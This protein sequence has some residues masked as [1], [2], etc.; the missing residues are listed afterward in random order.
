MLR[1]FYFNITHGKWYKQLWQ[2]EN[3]VKCD[4][5]CNRPPIYESIWQLA[6][7]N[8]VLERWKSQLPLSLALPHLLFT[9]LIH[10]KSIYSC[11]CTS[12]VIRRTYIISK[13]AEAFYERTIWLCNPNECATK[14]LS[15]RISATPDWGPFVI[16]I[17]SVAR[18]RESLLTSIHYVPH[19]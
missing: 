2:C 18:H 19:N 3:P 6:F 4:L 7:P 17:A 10:P 9:G 1:T 14:Q 8:N 15:N 12:V 13:W 16:N 11:P 5:D